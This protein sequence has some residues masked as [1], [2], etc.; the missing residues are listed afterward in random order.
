LW[1][2]PK[3]RIVGSMASVFDI[4]TYCAVHVIPKG[5]HRDRIAIVKYC[6]PKSILI[7]CAVVPLERPF[8]FRAEIMRELGSSV[9]HSHKNRAIVCLRSVGPY[10]FFLW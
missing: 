8:Q 1:L 7:S 2:V 4:D 6:C 9:I 3:G 5:N 10:S